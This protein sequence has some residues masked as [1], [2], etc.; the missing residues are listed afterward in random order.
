MC[1]GYSLVLYVFSTTRW[2]ILTL[3]QYV[4]QIIQVHVNNMRYKWQHW[5]YYNG[6]SYI[7]G[8]FLRQ[9]EVSF[10]V[11]YYGALHIFY[12]FKHSLHIVKLSSVKSTIMARIPGCQAISPRSLDP[13]ILIKLKAHYSKCLLYTNICTNK[14][15][16]F[17]KINPTYLGVNTP[18]SGSSQVVLAKVMNY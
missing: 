12:N 5:L 11:L 8:Q 9:K 10:D 6:C 3:Q 2:V 13:W 18:P 15:C 17:T 4:T 16:K 14:R 1:Q 7:P